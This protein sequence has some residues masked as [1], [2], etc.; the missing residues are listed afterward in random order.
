MTASMALLESSERWICL[1]IVTYVAWTVSSCRIVR[2]A[3]C[4]FEDCGYAVSNISK[5]K[6]VRN[7]PDRPKNLLEVTESDRF[8]FDE[9]SCRKEVRAAVWTDYGCAIRTKN[10]LR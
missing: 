5:L 3:C 2:R 4:A 6:Q 7:F 8:D 1:E 10:S 9:S